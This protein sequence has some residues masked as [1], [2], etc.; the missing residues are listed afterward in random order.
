[1]G[2]TFPPWALKHRDAVTVPIVTDFLKGVKADPTVGRVVAVG[3]CFGA[4]QA[5]LAASGEQPLV[6]CVIILSRVR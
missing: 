3:F 4:R 6:E 2:A 5:V 1:M